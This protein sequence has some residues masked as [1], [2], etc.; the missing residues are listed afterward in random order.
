MI[1]VVVGGGFV[2]GGVVEVGGAV[3]GGIVVGGGAP[4]LGGGAWPLLTCST[5]VEFCGALLPPGGVVATT[6]PNGS[7][8]ATSFRVTWKPAVVMTFAAWTYCWP[9]T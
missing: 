4:V 5:T 1:V 6:M 3:V 9:T 8:D 7:N 2:V